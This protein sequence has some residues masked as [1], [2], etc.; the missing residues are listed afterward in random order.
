MQ[1]MAQDLVDR[2]DWVLTASK[3]PARPADRPQHMGLQRCTPGEVQTLYLAVLLHV[4]CYTNSWAE[5]GQRAFPKWVGLWKLALEQHVWVP[6]SGGKKT[7]EDIRSKLPHGTLI[8]IKMIGGHSLAL[9][10]PSV[11]YIFD[12]TGQVKILS[13]CMPLPSS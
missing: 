8:Y 7:A 11:M 5:F 3:A 10:P 13:A 6:K 2:M 1:G 12:T 9:G 4:C